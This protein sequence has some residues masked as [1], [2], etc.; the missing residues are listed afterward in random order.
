MFR[1]MPGP[2]EFQAGKRRELEDKERKFFGRRPEAS[3]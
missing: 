3:E 2:E 1:G